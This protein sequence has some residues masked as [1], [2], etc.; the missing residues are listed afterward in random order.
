[1]TSSINFCLTSFQGALKIQGDINWFTEINNSSTN[2]F[3]YKFQLC[4]YKLYKK[5]KTGRLLT[6]EALRH[7]NWIL[8]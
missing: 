1:M 6:S 3:S 2:Q 7:F 4:I 8:I 5:L